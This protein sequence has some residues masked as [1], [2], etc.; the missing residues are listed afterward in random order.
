[1]LAGRG[2]QEAAIQAGHAGLARARQLGLARQIAAPIAGN[3]AD[4]LVAAGRWDEA[5]ETLDEILGL[6]VP[7]R[8][9]VHALLVHGQIAV[10]RGDLDGGERALRELRAL[11][12]GL[13]AEAHYS[14]PLARL[15]IEFRL[16]AGDLAGAAVAAGTLPGYSA[17]AD[18]QYLWPLLATAMQAWAE[19][20]GIRLP[21]AAGTP[22]DMRD[23][24]KQ[25]AAGAARL[26]P[27]NDGYAAL[28]A[29]EAARIDGRQD[30]RGWDTAVTA[31]EAA[32]QPYPLSYA[33]SRAAEAAAAAGDRDAAASRLRRAD[34]LAGQLGAR[35]LQQRISQL[36]RRS[37]IQLAGPG[38]GDPDGGAAVP[39]GL[40]P[41]ELE[42]L[43]LVAAGRS[44]REIAADLFISPRTA[45]VHVSNI[46]AKLAVTS[47]GEA[48][49][50]AHRLHLTDPGGLV[51]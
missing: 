26:N 37:R 42:V 5:A 36:A 31:W 3:L 4:A 50:A 29:A 8:G 48:A 47:R 32:G 1:V 51:S 23:D 22:A 6:D 35:P 39:F 14:L 19:A 33:L 43:R 27:V 41:R 40:T 46:L 24:L 10:A 15:E 34:G 9:R 11:P 25:R 7:P 28:L 17:Q 12:A 20:S 30:V 45:S 2:S 13:P 16:A 38:S 18:P 44:N 21:P 49:A